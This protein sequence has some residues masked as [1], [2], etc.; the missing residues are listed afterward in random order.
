MDGSL[1][2]VP[3]LGST[4]MT[5]LRRSRSP[6]KLV[7]SLVLTEGHKNLDGRIISALACKCSL[8]TLVRSLLSAT[9]TLEFIIN[10]SQSI[11]SSVQGAFPKVGIRMTSM[12]YPQP[13]KMVKVEMKFMIQD[14][15]QSCEAVCVE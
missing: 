6:Y 12:I 4:K 7:G 13:R 11:A 10:I 8:P 1:Q 2:A 14:L 3:W 9:R 15:V 5:S